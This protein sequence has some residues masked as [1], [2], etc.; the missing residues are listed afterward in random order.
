MTYM[1][2]IKAY[3]PAYLPTYLPTYIHTYI[4]TYIH[5]Y[6]LSYLPV[7]IYAYIPTYIQRI[8]PFQLVAIA[9]KPRYLADKLANCRAQQVS[10]FAQLGAKPEVPSQVQK[11][12]GWLARVVPLGELDVLPKVAV[13]VEVARGAVVGASVSFPPNQ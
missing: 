11:V 1:T 8:P 4:Q 6:I 2:Y 5:T 3:L 13:A 12:S 10:R 9:T 7:Y